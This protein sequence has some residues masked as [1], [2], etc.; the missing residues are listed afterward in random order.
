V[1]GQVRTTDGRE[2]VGGPSRRK[3]VVIVGRGIVLEVLRLQLR[4]LLGDK[5][6]RYAGVRKTFER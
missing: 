3:R 2:G 6:V 5:P 1:H 4:R